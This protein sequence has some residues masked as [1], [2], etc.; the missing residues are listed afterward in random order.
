MIF[1]F[2]PSNLYNPGSVVSLLCVTCSGNIIKCP[3]SVLVLFVKMSTAT[4]RAL[5]VNGVMSEDVRAVT[6]LAL[7]DFHGS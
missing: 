3:W 7:C 5:C 6:W 2:P 1:V 4:G